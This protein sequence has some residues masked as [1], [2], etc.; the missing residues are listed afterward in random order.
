GMIFQARAQVT[1]SSMTGH[2]QDGNNTSV[3][4]ATVRVTHVPS[5]TNY[6]TLTNAS[7]RYNIAN[8]RVGGPYREEVSYVGKS[9]VSYE[10]IYLQ[11]GAPHVPNIVFDDWS[12]VHEEE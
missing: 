6:P 9:P 7:G 1:T 4:G 5:G 10:N 8:M 3:D 11:L 2:V 12:T